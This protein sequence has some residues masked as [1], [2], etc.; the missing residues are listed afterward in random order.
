ME[1]ILPQDVRINYCSDIDSEY[2]KLINILNK[3][4]NG[5]CHEGYLGHFQLNVS[6]QQA[7]AIAKIYGYP[8]IDKGGYIQF[9]SK[10]HPLFYLLKATWIFP[11]GSNLTVD[12]TLEELKYADIL[13]QT[14]EYF[15]NDKVKATPIFKFDSLNQYHLNQSFIVGKKPN[16]LFESIKQREYSLDIYADKVF[17]NNFH[18]PLDLQKRVYKIKKL[19]V[20]LSAFQKNKLLF[21]IKTEDLIVKLIYENKKIE[22]NYIA[23]LSIYDALIRYLTTEIG[24]Q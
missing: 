8:S 3:Y 2:E 16:S 11:D 20:K 24:A 12:E 15:R 14:E 1:A 19:Y 13:R 23:L 9:K 21:G 4:A 7:V 22:Y 6:K 10:W 18:F 17:K 5:G